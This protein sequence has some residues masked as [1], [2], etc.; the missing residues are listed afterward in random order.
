MSDKLFL[1]SQ[2]E[3][4]LSKVNRAVYKS[5]FNYAIRC[6]EEELEKRYK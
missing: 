4:Y 5:P 6:F 1:L 3:L 2:R